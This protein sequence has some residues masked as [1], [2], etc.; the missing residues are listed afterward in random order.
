MFF[1]SPLTHASEQ[2]LK[3]VCVARGAGSVWSAL[4]YCFLLAVNFL[5]FFCSSVSGKCGFCLLLAAYRCE[6]SLS[7]RVVL[8]FFP[9]LQPFL[10][11]ETPSVELSQIEFIL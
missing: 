6:S 11:Q 4:F 7:W 10:F 8:T 9:S 1:C 3:C 5:R 2:Y